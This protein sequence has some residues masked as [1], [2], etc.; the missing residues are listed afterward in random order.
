[1]EE[2]PYDNW[3]QVHSG[4][5]KV[6]IIKG[7]FISSMKKAIKTLSEKPKS[8]PQP[9]KPKEVP[10]EKGDTPYE[11]WFYRNCDNNNIIVRSA[12]KVDTYESWFLRHCTKR[13]PEPE[14]ASKYEAWFYRNCDNRN[15]PNLAEI[16]AHDYDHWFKKHCTKTEK[17]VVDK[18]YA[19]W[20]ERNKDSKNPGVIPPPVMTY[21]IWFCKH[22]TPSEPVKPELI[23]ER[24]YDVWF[25]AHA[26]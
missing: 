6:E 1:M 11:K 17:F 19:A 13:A 21:D 12:I 4:M 24:P 22:K 5:K 20:F 23:V 10:K 3:F 16:N 2:R 14:Y 18:S 26:R 15:I 9:E 7:G 8:N 25:K